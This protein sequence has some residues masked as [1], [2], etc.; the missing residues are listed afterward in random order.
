MMGALFFDMRAVN[1]GLARPSVEV[2]PAR[3]VAVLGAGVMGAGIAYACARA[4]LDVVVK[5]VTPLLAA[6]A[7]E[8]KGDPAV[9]ARITTTADA[10]DLA[11][12]D[13]LIEAV[14]EDPA[15]KHAVYAEV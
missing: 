9:L 10:R 2:A 3:K 4:G 14:F 5:D 11:G 12:C 6:R 1:G 7:T 13:V 15:L 8:Q